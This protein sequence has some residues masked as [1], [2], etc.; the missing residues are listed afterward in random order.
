MSDTKEVRKGILR[1]GGDYEN[2][3]DADGEIE[4]QAIE[5]IHEMARNYI[6]FGKLHD[7]GK[8]LE[9]YYVISWKL[10]NRNYDH[11]KK[12]DYLL[13]LFFGH[14]PF[15]MQNVNKIYKQKRIDDTITRYDMIMYAFPA[16]ENA[17]RKYVV[18]NPYGARF[19]AYLEKNLQGR[20]LRESRHDSVFSRNESF[21]NYV[22]SSRL[23]GNNDNY[24]S[25]NFEPDDSFR[26]YELEFDQFE[27]EA[28]DKELVNALRED[29][30]DHILAK[31]AREIERF[32]NGEIDKMRKDILSVLY[33]TN[34]LADV[35]KQN[36]EI[37]DEFYNS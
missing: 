3:I 18:Y 35:V 29:S 32:R 30:F 34:K 27:D 24:F 19:L 20:L 21:I 5:K 1:Q 22:V 13:K 9:R 28:I 36:L 33:I 4:R 11:D 14:L 2:K 25:E 16:F 8:T 6:Q 37:Y 23:K 17:L 31:M 10:A 7:S 15:V 12:S 26:D